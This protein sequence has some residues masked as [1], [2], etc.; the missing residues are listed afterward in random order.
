MQRGPSPQKVDAGVNRTHT[1]LTRGPG[2]LR[3]WK[4]NRMILS[5]L[6]I[7]LSQGRSCALMKLWA[8]CEASEDKGSG[9]KNPLLTSPSRGRVPQHQKG[10]MLTERPRALRDSR[11]CHAQGGVCWCRACSLPPLQRTFPFLLYVNVK[12]GQSNGICGK[13]WRRKT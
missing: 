7:C 1:Q 13:T 8:Q 12:F 9:G 2:L 4:E 6:D 3:E 5:P 10:M 11:P